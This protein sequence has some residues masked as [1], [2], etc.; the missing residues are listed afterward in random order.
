[1]DE[2]GF[3]IDYGITYL[4]ITVDK[5][6]LLRFVNLDNRDYII[7]MKCISAER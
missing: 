1:M 5:S 2:I 3:R 6:K 4:V 7:S